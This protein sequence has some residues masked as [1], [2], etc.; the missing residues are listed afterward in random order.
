MNKTLSTVLTLLAFV[1]GVV[2]LIM[3]ILI[4]SGN[5]G[6]IDSAITLTMI[7]MLAAAVIAILFGLFHFLQNIKHNIPMLI[8]VVVFVIIAIIC[9]N[10]AGSEVL[11]AYGEGI[12]AS[13]SKWS[14]AGLM[15]MYVL[16]IA[17]I[18]AALIGEVSRI[19][20]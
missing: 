19:F 3:G 2:G 4:M 15:V 10:L 9:Y 8:G 16:I 13:T 5:E 20:K 18:V 6:V 17:A 12:T 1:I 14:G 11:K 7:V